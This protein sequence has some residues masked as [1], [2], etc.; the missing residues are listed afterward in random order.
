MCRRKKPLDILGKPEESQKREI[1]D[2]FKEKLCETL[3][4]NLKEEFWKDLK[5]K[6]WVE[7]LHLYI[8]IPAQSTNIKVYI[9]N[10]AMYDH[11]VY[12]ITD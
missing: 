9:Q 2:N 1:L 11:I 12:G 6:A 8:T 4:V 3:E 5:E 7:F 10:D